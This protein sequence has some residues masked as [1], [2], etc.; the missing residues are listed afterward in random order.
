M[1]LGQKYFDFSDWPEPFVRPN[2]QATEFVANKFLRDHFKLP[3]KHE[4]L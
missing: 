4:Y 2:L 1:L 3:Y